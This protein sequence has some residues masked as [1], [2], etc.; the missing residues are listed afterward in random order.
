[1]KNKFNIPLKIQCSLNDMIP[2]C[3]EHYTVKYKF[4]NKKYIS[5]LINYNPNGFFIIKKNDNINE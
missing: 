1:M 2:D 3:I 4:N 5:R